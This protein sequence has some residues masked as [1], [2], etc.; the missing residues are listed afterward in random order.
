MPSFTFPYLELLENP[1]RLETIEKATGHTLQKRE[2]VIRRSYPDWEALRKKGEEIRTR[3]VENLDKLLDQFIQAQER[4]GGEV[5]VVEK[6][7][8]VY[9]WVVRWL[10]PVKDDPIVKAKS[11]VTEELHLREYLQNQGFQVVETDLGEFLIALK[12]DLPS[13]IT[14]P[15]IHL[16]REEVAQLLRERCSYTGSAEPQ[17]MVAFMRAYLREK[18]LKA[19][20]GIT[21]ANFL[22][23]ENGRIV[24]LE[25]EGNIRW[26][27]TVPHRQ[28]VVTTLEKLIPKMED[29]AI[30][31]KLLPP[32]AT[33][34]FMNTYTS[35][36]PPDKKRKIIIYKGWRKEL[37][38]NPWMKKTLTCIRCGA[39]M[40]A[41]PVFRTIGGHGYGTVVPG[42]IGI[43]QMPYQDKK[44]YPLLE[45]C[46]LCGACG[47]ICPVRIPLPELILRRRQEV[48]KKFWEK[49]GMKGF[50]WI[51][52]PR[53]FN[54]T[55]RI[56]S[57]LPP[58]F[59][60]SWSRFRGAFPFS[61]PFFHRLWKRRRHP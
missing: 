55:L 45:L 2:A 30:L 58:L 28:V 43:L 21:G 57:Y 52:K 51:R 5:V 40:V 25:N 14:A 59:M 1:Q 6:Q 4:C 61:R 10:E 24:L 37:L 34:Q 50:G 49:M 39:C 19:G 27:T 13:H 20:G 41:C 8:E 46:T 22:V 33:G 3:A 54:F 9:S 32:S 31:L 17:A 35:L 36:L 16:H 23:A 26:T 11:M 53:W 60:A 12:G 42:P 56:L 38:Q 15:A 44:A 29:L 47:D 18:F 7:E 48:P